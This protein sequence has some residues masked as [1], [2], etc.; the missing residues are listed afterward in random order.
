M[1][2]KPAG[3][4]RL[5]QIVDSNLDKLG[6]RRLERPVDTLH[7]QQQGPD[8]GLAQCGKKAFVVSLFDNL[9][10]IHQ[11]NFVTHLL[12]D[13]KIMTD[14]KTSQ[15]KLLLK[16]LQQVPNLRLHGNV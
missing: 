4:L 12:H 14:E 15:T 5:R 8:I 1:G 3:G 6:F 16:P 11:N 7:R 13:A 10:H 2:S 9:D